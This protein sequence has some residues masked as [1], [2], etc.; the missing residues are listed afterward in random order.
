MRDLW[1]DSHQF[2]VP[3]YFSLML[4]QRYSNGS[5]KND[6]AANIRKGKAYAD[7]ARKKIGKYGSINETALAR[8]HFPKNY[9][10]TQYS[11]TNL[12]K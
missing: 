4:G 8:R 1:L 3:M 9:I 5:G 2:P 7:E 11:I 6:R 12:Y 10:T